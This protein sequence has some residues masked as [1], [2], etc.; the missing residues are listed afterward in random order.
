[1]RPPGGYSVIMLRFAQ[2]LNQKC[3]IKLNGNINDNGCQESGVEPEIFSAL[4]R[5]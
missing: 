3:G 5:L 1:M 4:G 2:A